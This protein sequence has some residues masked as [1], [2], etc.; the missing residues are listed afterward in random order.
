MEQPEIK[1]QFVREIAQSTIIP[2]LAGFGFLAWLYGM[3]RSPYPG[4][5]IFPL[6]AIL[7]IPLY[8]FSG[9]LYG[10]IL[11]SL[12]T[13]IGFLSFTLTRVQAFPLI[14]FLEVLWLWA[15][16]M[17]VRRYQKSYIDG[18]NRM[19][20]N[21]EVLETRRALLDSALNEMSKRKSTLER[22]IMDYRSLGRMVR[23]FSSTLAE[24]KVIPLIADTASKFIGR[25][26]WKVKKSTHGDVV[27][28]Y[29][30]KQKLPLIISDLSVDNRF[31]VERQRYASMI[32][33]PLEVNNS[34]WGILEG[35]SQQPNVFD[36]G[37]LR[38]LSIIG[39]IASLAL[40]NCVLYKHT[41]E[42]AITDGLTGLYVQGYFKDRL[43]EEMLRSQRHRLP[44][45]VAILDIDHFKD[46]NDTYGHIAGDAILRQLADLLRHRLRETD[47]VC[48]YGGEEFGIIML[49]TDMREAYNVCDGIRLNVEA[50]RFYLPVESFK[51]V[52]VR[53]TV[54]IGLA[55]LSGG[56]TREN[57]LIKIADEALYRA[58]TG[59]RNRVELGYSDGGTQ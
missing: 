43:Q 29:I 59:G 23:D 32:A 18:Q 26:V 53:V 25:G 24:D 57:E 50:E 22:R 17:A 44:L 55:K 48:R 27:A 34:F 49:Q 3:I 12:L 8:L 39:G 41:Q 47:F 1:E 58:K 38:L 56:I 6:S 46:F 35:M 14:Y 30:K 42:L 13:L 52:Q 7:L 21:E 36:E 10:G 51:P 37:D 45:T 4:I 9:F 40:N 33:I 20:E 54:S 31:H 28:Q 2:A 5:L 11:L 16:I 19:R 15:M